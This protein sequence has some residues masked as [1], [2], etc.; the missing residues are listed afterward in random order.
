MPIIDDTVVEY[1]DETIDVQ[2]TINGG[3]GTFTGGL[4]FAA[5]TITIIDN[6]GKR[7]L[8]SLILFTIWNFQ[9]V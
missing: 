4:S 6:D 7:A 5:T 8:Y 1:N 3:L 9:S 2:C